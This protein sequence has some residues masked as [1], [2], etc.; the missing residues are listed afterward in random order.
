MRGALLITACLLV[1]AS[2]GG[3]D[4]DAGP[5]ATTAKSTASNA[6]DTTDT[7]T[8]TIPGTDT[9]VG[10]EPTEPTEL[11][12]S[13]GSEPTADVIDIEDAIA[14][15]VT[16]NGSSDPV[17]SWSAD[18][19]VRVA[20]LDLESFAL[21]SPVVASGDLTPIGHP[22][23][24]PAI[25]VGDDDV[26]HVAFTSFV[27]SDGSVFY[28]DVVGDQ[29]TDPTSISGEPRPETNLVHMT[30]ADEAP[31][32]AWLEDSTLSVAPPVD[33][34]PHEIEAVDD[35]TCDCCNP[36]PVRL[37]DQ[38]TVAYRNQE[39]TADGIIRDVYAIT[40][41]DG[42]TSFD[43]PVP[44]A[45]D[46]WFLDGCPFSGPAV[47]R[48]GDDLLV[49]WMDARQSLHPDQDATTIWI[50]RSTDGGATWGTDRAITDD[51]IHRWSSLAV[52]E[53]GTVHL[54]WE[55]Q[56][57]DGGISY[58][59]STDDGVTFGPPAALIPNTP[60]SGLRRAPSMFVHGE[61]LLVT[62]V[63]RSGGHVTAFDLDSLPS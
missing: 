11:T 39:H 15:N 27:G 53:R 55:T 23:E 12:E 61:H 34:T 45:D 13:G 19:A 28:V 57:T 9:V 33:G 8:G 2:C 7:D 21:G 17:V 31:T 46:H 37:G 47:I 16:G 41:H 6:V 18:D 59:A 63:D 38:L 49:T 56:A 58:S 35:L 60:D 36:V 5:A 1:A 50:D 44:V 14:I 52:D 20:R 4:G 25:S 40:S 43:E 48:V 51:G 22:I 32:L 62:W 10:T 42:G 24:R 29:P 3:D 26:V 54:L 30:L